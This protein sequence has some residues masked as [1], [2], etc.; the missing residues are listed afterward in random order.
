M[1][2][3]KNAK[4]KMQNYSA[5]G[6]FDFPPAAGFLILHFAFLIDGSRRRR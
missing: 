1:R 6:V 2:L 3:I 5:L 4:C